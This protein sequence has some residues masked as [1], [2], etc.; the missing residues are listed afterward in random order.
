MFRSTRSSVALLLP[1]IKVHKHQDRENQE[2]CGGQRTMDHAH[3]NSKD[4]VEDHKNRF[5]LVVDRR[6]PLNLSI[7]SVRQISGLRH[8]LF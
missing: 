3:E 2:Q 1:S 8:N 7:Q 5:D 6:N 4:L